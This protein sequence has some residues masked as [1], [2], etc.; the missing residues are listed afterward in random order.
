MAKDFGLTKSE[1]AVL[2]SFAHL[3]K[4]EQ[5]AEQLNIAVS[6]VRSHLKQIHTKMSVN[7]SIQLLRITR[8]Y[9]DS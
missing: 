6:T 5:I 4:P 9:T 7:S 8:A 3:K 2:D 1:C